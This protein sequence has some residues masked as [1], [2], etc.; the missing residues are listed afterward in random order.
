MP[1][2]KTT[3]VTPMTTTIE[4]NPNSDMALLGK[5]LMEMETIPSMLTV[6]PWTLS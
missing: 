4:R 2:R 1:R 3:D 6:K 5:P